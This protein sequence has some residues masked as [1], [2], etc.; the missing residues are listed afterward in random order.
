MKKVIGILILACF[1][2]GYVYA[3]DLEGTV[4]QY[5]TYPSYVKELTLQ[6]GEKLADN[7]DLIAFAQKTVPADKVAI[8]QVIIRVRRIMDAELW[9]E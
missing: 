1:M 2:A 3:A 6:E 4:S 5:T 8:V 9:N 7:A